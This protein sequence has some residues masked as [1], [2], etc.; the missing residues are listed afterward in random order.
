MDKDKVIDYVMNSPANTN[1][2]VLEG[3]LDDSGSGGDCGYSCTENEKVL[4]SEIVTT[5]SMSASSSIG[6][7]MEGFEYPYLPFVTV[8][9]N[10]EVYNDIPLRWDVEVKNHYYGEMMYGSPLFNTYPFVIRNNFT[11]GIPYLYTKTA[12][13]YEITI[14]TDETSYSDCFKK[15]V[16]SAINGVKLLK[17]YE[18]NSYGNTVLAY[19]ENG[20]QQFLT[21]QE[22]RRLLALNYVIFYYEVVDDP[23]MLT[24]ASQHFDW[25][26]NFDS[27]RWT[28]TVNGKNFSTSTYG[29]TG[30][31]T[32]TV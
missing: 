11:Q 6:S 29:G 28:F 16:L 5:E 15:A 19:T 1:R 9:I 22:L 21:P 24:K 20:Q 17:I 18:T 25:D 23:S 27:N 31:Y 14:L 3:M 8:V 13:D 2:A 10:G 4:W 7:P 26:A 32:Y 30:I 12:G